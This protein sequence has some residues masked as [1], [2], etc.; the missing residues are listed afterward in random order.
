[1]RSHRAVAMNE[2]SARTANAAVPR[3]D[4]DKAL[5][6]LNAE[7]ALLL[8]ACDVSLWLTLDGTITDLTVTGAELAEDGAA[9]W[10]GC[11]LDELVTVECKTKVAEMLAEAAA[12]GAARWR[13]VTHP[14]PNGEVPVRYACVM[15]GD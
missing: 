11:K 12:G 5:V 7:A 1:M 14:M 8:A 3:A 10:R 4:G 15:S 13:Q 6:G 2:Q 9:H